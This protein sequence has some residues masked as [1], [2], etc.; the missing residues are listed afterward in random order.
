MAALI[1][2]PLTL[3]LLIVAA[4]VARILVPSRRGALRRA[5]IYTFGAADRVRHPGR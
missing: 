5:G 3:P 4:V 1:A 2:W